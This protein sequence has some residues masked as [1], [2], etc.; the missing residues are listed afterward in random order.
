[1]L[2]LVAHRLPAVNIKSLASRALRMGLV[3]FA[4]DVFLKQIAAV[5][6]LIV[7]RRVFLSGGRLLRSMSRSLMS[8][9]N[10]E[11]EQAYNLRR[12]RRICKDYTSFRRMG[13]QLDKVLGLDKW[14]RDS[15]SRLFDAKMLQERT[16]RY[17]T[18]MGNGDVEGCLF[19]LR[20]E[21]LR[22]HFGICNPELFEV[23]NSG[24]KEVVENYVETVCQ[25][26]TWVALEHHEKHQEHFPSQRPVSIAEKVAFFSETKHS[27]GRCA[28]L[29]SG[30]GQLG[31]YHFGVVKALYQNGLLPRVISG[32]SSGSIVCGMLAV[33]TDAELEIM[34]SPNFNWE[35]NL[36]LYFIGG[37]D[38]NRFIR[39]QA[40]YDADV[41]ARS[42]KDNIGETTTFLEAFDMTGRICNI[43]VS[44]LPGTTQYPM[45]LNYLTSPHVLIWSAACASAA[46]PGVFEP[47]ELFA[48]DRY[49][50]IVSYYPGGLKWRDGSMQ[51]DLPMTRL[52]EMFNVNFFIV[53]Q[54]NPHAKILS[55]GGAV[56]SRGPIFRTAQFLRRELKQYLL[57]IAEFGSGTAGRRVSPWF[58]PVGISAIGLLVQEY[59]GDI[60]IFNGRGMRELTN[61]FING[62]NDMLRRY[63]AASQLETWKRIPQIE[64]ACKIEFVMEEIL[65]QLR[66]ET[67]QKKGEQP[68]SN[69][70]QHAPLLTAMVS[71]D[72]GMKRLPSFQQDLA[73]S[74][75]E[76]AEE[77]K[78]DEKHVEQS[79]LLKSGKSFSTPRL[80]DA[81]REPQRKSSSSR[82][83]ATNQ[84]ML[85]LLVLEES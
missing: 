23:T 81:V 6:V 68:K 59:E 44:G 4:P 64:N 65:K 38:F 46:V 50:Q 33:R 14:K 12:Q 26:M 37:S 35:E 25:T 34:W 9:V 16:Q 8:L 56:S 42:L 32:T 31:M 24:T 20:H 22:K 51:N 62:S 73:K 49:G 83:F 55:G 17:Q 85:N 76:R 77:Q 70:C 30:G 39:R 48:K 19:H 71:T 41:L 2:R 13:E 82:L 47:R 54:V 74:M 10:S 43:T 29:L 27:F 18:L 72:L 5:M 63:T 61:L 15:N 52:T 45:L 3:I 21:L 84:S 28:L 11:A 53:S 60:T 79:P 40:F 7:L 57:S 78:R 75:A 58:R 66:S 67:L 1:M 36:N 69:P 80:G